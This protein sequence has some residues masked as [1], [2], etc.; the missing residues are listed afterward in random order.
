MSR[1]PCRARLRSGDGSP[2]LLC[3][4]QGLKTTESSFTIKSCVFSRGNKK[5]GLQNLIQNKIAAVISFLLLVCGCSITHQ[6]YYPQPP[7]EK[8]AKISVSFRGVKP[9]GV[10]AFEDADTCAEM[11]D[12]FKELSEDYL[13]TH[14]S[15]RKYKSEGDIH[16]FG[17][18]DIAL[19]AGYQPTIQVDEDI[20][21]TG[22]YSMPRVCRSFIKFRPEPGM[23]YQL[24]IGSGPFIPSEEQLVQMRK[25]IKKATSL[26][27]HIPT[28]E[29]RP[30]FGVCHAI[31]LTRVSADEQRSPV[32][33]CSSGK[34]A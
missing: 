12:V 20:Y 23:N 28:I 33:L 14:W 8:A 1:E 15:E 10:Y 7:P 9:R 3:F 24:T 25:D 17:G 30:N 32:S 19:L 16:V 6:K 22:Y 31:E 27:K 4:C 5:V 29:F 34:R 18:K 26:G 2:A 13:N 11:P 21:T